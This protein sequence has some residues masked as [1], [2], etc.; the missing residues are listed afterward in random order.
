MCR[1]QID[2]GYRRSES[3]LWLPSERRT[4]PWSR[5][6]YNK[7]KLMASHVAAPINNPAPAFVQAKS[8]ALQNQAGAPPGVSFTSNITAGNTVVVWTWVNGGSNGTAITSSLGNTYAKISAAS[9]GVNPFLN[10]WVATNVT[11]GT[12]T[13][14]FNCSAGDY[15]QVQAEYS[16]VRTAT[17]TDSAISETG[18][19]SSA[20]PYTMSSVTTGFTNETIVGLAITSS[21][22]APTAGIGWTGRN[23]Q[24]S[25]GI[26]GLLQEIV[27]A[28]AGTSFA[29]AWTNASGSSLIGS[30]I[31]LRA[32]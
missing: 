8:Y 16:G 30:V 19:A 29:P 18:A 2:N 11:G 26:A 31:G 12:E 32:N 24:V 25:G 20:N 5:G 10:V 14:T 6:A 1:R 13:L 27:K 21:G 23:T 17:P 15:I 9:T 7:A 22:S 28:T 4:L 3:G